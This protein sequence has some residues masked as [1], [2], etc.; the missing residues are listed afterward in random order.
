MSQV[1]VNV[2]KLLARTLRRSRSLRL[3]RR[4][5]TV[6]TASGVLV[7]LVLLL[8]V[9]GVLPGRDRAPG[10]NEVH[11]G[12]WPC[13][14]VTSSQ[15]ACS[16]LPPVA[17]SPQVVVLTF[18]QALD[19]HDA[20]LAKQL[21]EPGFRAEAESATDSWFTNTLSITDVEVL[22]SDTKYDAWRRPLPAG[23]SEVINVSTR[24]V[25]RQRVERSMDDGDTSE[26]FTLVRRGPGSRWL[27]EEIGMG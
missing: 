1:D 21:L 5:L 15:G 12:S 20:K 9:V 7:S 25:L 23:Y 4:V 22:G 24:F 3:R 6:A 2:D 17:A 10:R 18:L 8:L 19:R 26:N 11:V 13:D 16:E 27:I 14:A